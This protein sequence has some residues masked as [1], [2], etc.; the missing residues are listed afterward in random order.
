VITRIALLQ[1]PGP[2]AFA[3]LSNGA[4]I[5]ACLPA[6]RSSQSEM[7]FALLGSAGRKRSKI[8]HIQTICRAKDLQAEVA[9]SRADLTGNGVHLSCAPALHLVGRCQ[10]VCTPP[11]LHHPIQHALP[12]AHQRVTWPRT[13][14]QSTLQLAVFV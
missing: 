2:G 4:P 5:D 12:Q 14:N 9:N 1:R 11:T 13:S 7:L 8:Q 3:P 6:C 10:S